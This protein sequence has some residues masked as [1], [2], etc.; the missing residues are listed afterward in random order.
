MPKRAPFRNARQKSPGTDPD[1]LF[2]S[3]A[4]ADKGPNKHMRRW[5]PRAMGRATRVA[6]SFGERGKAHLLGYCLGGTLL[7][8]TLAWMAANGDERIKSATFFVTLM[9]FRESGEL[10][11]FIDEEQIKL[12][13]EKMNKRGYL[14]GNEMATTWKEIGRAHV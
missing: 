9:D 1:K 4:T 11:V 8:S 14:E 5:R 3:K 10:N 2:V 13:E 7:S 6:A 12:L